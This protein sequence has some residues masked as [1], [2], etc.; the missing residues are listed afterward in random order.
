MN[1]ESKEENN[2]TVLKLKEKRL[3]AHIAVN[4]KQDVA[5]RVESGVGTLVL[6]MS[7]VEFIDSSGLG[8][9]VSCLKLVGSKGGKMS[10]CGLQE[11][12]FSM[13]KLTRMD[14][15]FSIYPTEEEALAA[16]A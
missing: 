9:V 14:Q 2:V 5:D 12:T 4:Y 13:F 7:E 6:D 11:S 3:D 16:A 15:V 8:A 10:I 1:V